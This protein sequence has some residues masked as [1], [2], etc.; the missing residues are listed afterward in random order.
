M[1]WFPLYKFLKRVY[2]KVFGNPMALNRCLRIRT[3][4][5]V[6][7]R[8]VKGKILD[9][10]CGDG[11]FTRFLIREKAQVYAIDVTDWGISQRLA[12]VSFQIADGRYL[13]YADAAFDFVF[14]SDVLE[15]VPDCNLIVRDI[16]RVLR[17]GGRCL[18]STVHGYWKSPWKLRQYLMRHLP[19]WLGLRIMGRFW[20]N[21]TDLHREILGHVR[22]D[23]E[24]NLVA[25]WLQSAG[26]DIVE[27]IPY[28]KAWGSLLM[29]VYF[30]FND[31]LRYF[32]YPVLRMFLWLDQWIGGEPWQ[33]ALLGLKKT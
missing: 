1:S 28:C 16:G 24:P 32:I 33:Y 27:I 12:G 2:L 21:D 13:P 9:V 18:I 15:H 25:G 4:V 22:Y 14:C 23:L 31:R 11:S 29:E 6:L 8:W 7:T 3:L 30:C 19:A 17:P 5:P 26:V 10:G 20:T